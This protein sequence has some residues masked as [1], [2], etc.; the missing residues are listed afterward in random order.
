MIVLTDTFQKYKNTCLNGNENGLSAFYD[1]EFGAGASDVFDMS[2]NSNNGTMWEMDD[3]LSWVTG[4]NCVVTSV[5]EDGFEKN[6]RIYPNPNEGI[7]NLE[8]DDLKDVKIKVLNLQGKLIYNTEN[9]NSNNY[10]F[11]LNEEAGIYFLEIQSQNK[12]QHF[13]LIRN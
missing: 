2:P 8:L 6:V 3:N 4:F 5:K 11:E 12:K 13:K 9:I 10:Q 7:I 1:F